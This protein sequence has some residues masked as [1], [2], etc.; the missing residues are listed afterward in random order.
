[1][2]RTAGKACPFRAAITI[3]RAVDKSDS[4]GISGTAGLYGETGS[5]APG[6]QSR[7]LPGGEY[8]QQSAPSSPSSATLAGAGHEPKAGRWGSGGPFF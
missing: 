2:Q 4:P 1:M 8:G 6:V 7:P 5:L 3:V